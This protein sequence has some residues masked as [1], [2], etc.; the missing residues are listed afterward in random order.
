MNNGVY[1]KKYSY[2]DV[3]KN[4]QTSMQVGKIQYSGLLGA[5]S[6]LNYKYT[7]DDLGNIATVTPS[8][9][10]AERYSYDAMG[11]L[12]GATLGGTEYVYTYDGAAAR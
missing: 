5:L 8:V 9:G 1:E 4:V 3:V 2:L 6:G 11:Q 10:D 12:T 7:Y